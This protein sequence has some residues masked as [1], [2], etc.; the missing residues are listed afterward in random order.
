[1]NKLK[2]S[3]IKLFST[4]IILILSLSISGCSKLTTSQSIISDKTTEQSKNQEVENKKTSAKIG[5]VGDIMVHSPQ[6]NAQL[7]SSTGEYSFDNNFEHVKTYIEECD[8]ALANLET[9]LKGAPYSGYPSFN[10]PDSLV[11][12]LKNTG[13]DVLSTINN[14]SNDTSSDGLSRTLDV[15]ENSGL[16]YVGTQK[17]NSDKDY[18]IK[19][20]NEIRLGILSYSYG[21]VS[22]NNKALN[23]IPIPKDYTDL[24]NIFDPSNPEEAFNN[25]KKQLDLIKKE[26]VDTIVLFIHWGQEYMRE[27]NSFQVELAQKLCDEGVD[28]IFGSHPH[29]VQPME[30]LKSSNSENETFVIYSLGNFLSNQRKDLMRSSYTEDGSIL[31][32][33]LEK[34]FSTNKTSIKSIN[35]LPTWVNKYHDTTKGK[36]VYEILPL[37]QDEEFYSDLETEGTFNNNLKSKLD[38]SY[39]NTTSLIKDDRIQAYTVK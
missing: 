30:I 10:S 13:F 8:L 37:T 24:V 3:Y 28:I 19:D 7:D 34:D 18:L 16:D 17:N 35:C 20:V 4:T 11:T 25:I 2:S 31:T 36:N 33:E 15:I 38:Q 29:V 32:V 14:H 23:G 39:E 1:M 12:A 21:T 27:P 9:T 6:L 22:E 5:A 26:E